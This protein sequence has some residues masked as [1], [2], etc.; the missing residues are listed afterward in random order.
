MT[1]E[2][3]IAR[4]ATSAFGLALLVAALILRSI[5]R[6]QAY[7]RD[8]KGVQVYLLLF[9]GTAALRALAPDRWRRVDKALFVAGLVLFAFAVIRGA[10]ATYSHVQRRRTGV[11]VPRILRDL[12]D[13]ILFVVAALIILQATL[14][15]DLSAVLASSAVLSIVLGL[16][17]QETLSNLFAGLS[18]QAERPFGEGDFVRIGT[19]QGKVL[20]VGWRATRLLTGAGEALTIPN[21][22]VAK[23]AVFNL[24]RLRTAQR[25]VALSAGYGVPPNALKEAALA[26][27]Q[28]HP[29]ALQ[30]PAPVVRTVDLGQNGI[31]YE[32]VFWVGR[33]EDGLPV[34]DDVRTQ[35]WYRLHRAGI[36]LSPLGSEVRLARSARPAAGVAEVEV[37]TLLDRVDFLAH[38]DAPLREALALRARVV[39]FGQGEV[40]VRRGEV[41]PSPFYVVAAGEVAVRVRSVDGSEREA[42]R[43]GP[44]DFFGEMGVLAG[45][46]GEGTV[47]AVKDCA[48]AALDREAFAELFKQAPEAAKKLAEVLARRREALSQARSETTVPAARP[49]EGPA[50]LDRLKGIFKHLR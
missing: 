24:S 14:S 12:F 9:L 37:K 13:G 40:V 19:Q 16:A 41:E 31:A 17:L 49:P 35:L 26:V 11:E 27:V 36:A 3:V 18:L 48:L 7:R 30:D 39:R 10:E 4:Y 1:L 20:E 46:A 8:L 5:S 2:D 42:A 32:L 44:G 25:K 15:I 33:F 34:E 28:A 43:L 22:T 29:K 6:E 21:N 23:E 50:V 45:E 47:V 38:V